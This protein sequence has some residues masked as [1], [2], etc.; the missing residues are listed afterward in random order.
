MY[1][2]LRKGSSEIWELGLRHIALYLLSGTSFI[3]SPLFS[4]PPHLSYYTYPS[5]P[6]LRI[7]APFPASRILLII[8]RT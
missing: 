4:P 5:K 8:V 3:L 6:P 7:P 2:G 1:L